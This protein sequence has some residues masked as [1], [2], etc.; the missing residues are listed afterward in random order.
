MTEI[1]EIIRS[2]LCVL[3]QLELHGMDGY[4]AMFYC[5]TGC[6]HRRE[7]LSGAKYSKD[8]KEHTVETKVK[9]NDRT[10]DELEDASKVLASCSYEQDTQWGR[11]VF[12]LLINST[13][14]ANFELT[15]LD[16]N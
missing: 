10:V 1:A 6:L 14:L 16:S 12:I 9:K 5:G 2:S 13:Q 3:L 7:S 8:C 11:E 15:L 4:G